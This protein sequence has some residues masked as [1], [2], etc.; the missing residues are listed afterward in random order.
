M[1]VFAPERT[2]VAVRAI[3]P[4]AGKPPKSGEIAHAVGHD[5]GHKRLDRSEN[6]HGE[7]GREQLPEDVVMEMGNGN[8]WQALR[9]STKAA[10][11]CFHGQMQEHDR[12]GRAKRN[13][14]CARNFLRILQA[15]NHYRNRKKGNRSCRHGERV[16]RL[17]IGFDAMEKI[18]GNVV[19]F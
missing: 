10:S 4:V 2:F 6:G 7:G 5:R 17:A 11:D 3:A 9:D 1:G 15:K 14:N 13:Q 16:P 19:H 18:A 8:G 12:G